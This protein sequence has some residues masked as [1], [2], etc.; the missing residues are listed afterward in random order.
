MSLD[1]SGTILFSLD[2]LLSSQTVLKQM[3]TQN[4]TTFQSLNVP[5]FKQNL[6]NWA[7]SG[8]ID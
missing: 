2:E 7:A 6:M 1:L 4:N 3:E 5:I 8:F